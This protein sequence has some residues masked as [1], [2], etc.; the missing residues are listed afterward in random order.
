MHG[1]DPSTVGIDIYD[2]C[3]RHLV[4][5]GN[6]NGRVVRVPTSF[7]EAKQLVCGIH[8]DFGHLRA[9]GMEEIVRE[10]LFVQ[11]RTQ[12]VQHVIDACETCQSTL[13]SASQVF[14]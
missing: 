12:L 2:L 10:R 5:T 14:G 8:I 3:D 9:E 4:R 1:E 13:A 7:D 11:F 6:A